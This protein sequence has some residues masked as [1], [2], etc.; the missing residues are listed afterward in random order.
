MGEGK[1][2]SK[3]LNEKG[4][5]KRKLQFFFFLTYGEQQDYLQGNTDFSYGN[6]LLGGEPSDIIW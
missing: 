2:C 6:T 3:R 1:H 5:G 4:Q